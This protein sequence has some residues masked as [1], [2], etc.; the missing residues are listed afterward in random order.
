MNNNNNAE[1]SYTVSQF[2]KKNDSPVQRIYQLIRTKNIDFTREYGVYLIKDT[3]E[4]RN[5]IK[6]D[7]RR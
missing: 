2:A 7:F 5:S 6:R 4:N 1:K 3:K